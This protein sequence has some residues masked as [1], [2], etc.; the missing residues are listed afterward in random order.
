MIGV[1]EQNARR[2]G[3]AL[4]FSRLTLRQRLKLIWLVLRKCRAWIAGDVCTYV[5]TEVHA[6]DQLR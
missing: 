3:V 5:R 6:E 1:S 4:D 2:I